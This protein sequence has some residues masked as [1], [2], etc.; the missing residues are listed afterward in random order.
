MASTPP[1]AL[2]FDIFRSVCRR[3]LCET[4]KSPRRKLR[5]GPSATRAVSTATSQVSEMEVENTPR[6]RWSYTPPAMHA[7]VRSRLRPQGVTPLTINA[8]PK[9]LDQMYI[10]FLGNNGDKML[11]EEVKWLAVTHKSFD[12]GRRGFNDRLSFLGA[13]PW[14]HGIRG[15]KMADK[16]LLVG[17]RVVD[18]QTTLALITSSNNARYLKD[19]KD[20]YGREPFQHPALEGIECLY[21]GARDYFLHHKRMVELS[22]QYG[23]PDV[24][25]WVPKKVSLLLSNESGTK[26]TD[27]SDSLTAWPLP[28]L[29]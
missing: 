7:P 13:W 21:G 14:D 26:S 27:T 4:S 16:N 28:V 17:K 19:Y 8:D 9:K 6:P 1:S 10:R 11:S 15:C 23:L 18:L 3:S 20:P 25:R 2:F 12:H 5:D 22:Q 29:I 24:V